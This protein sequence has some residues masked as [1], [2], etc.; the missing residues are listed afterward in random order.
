M[1]QSAE[2]PIVGGGGD[3]GVTLDGLDDV[4]Q[5]LITS[6]QRSIGHDHTMCHLHDRTELISR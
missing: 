4:G 5:G 6:G 3:S 1:G 2:D